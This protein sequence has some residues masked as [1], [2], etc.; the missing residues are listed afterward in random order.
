MILN[1]L[2]NEGQNIR[3]AYTR[4]LPSNPLKDYYFMLRNTGNTNAQIIE[5]GFLDSTKDDSL[6]LKNSWQK[7]AE[8]VV[9]A[10]AKY[11]NIPYEATNSN[12][13]IVRVGDTLW[14]IAKK[15]NIS[16]NELK[17]INN[18]TNNLLKI[19]M[20]LQIPNK[21]YSSIYVVK[22]GDTLY[23]IAKENSISVSDLKSLNNITSD[24]LKVGQEILVKDSDVQSYI[25]KTGDTLFNIAQR[26]G[27][28][29]NSIKTLNSLKN[30]ILTIGQVL[31]IK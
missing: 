19:G 10:I 6:Q 29:V 30:D 11:L 9:K 12:E 18:L 2:K 27:T 17:K 4:R 28:T 23:S 14:S 5:Y 25:V 15:Y 22:N 26:F 20:K 7:Y 13:Y 16:V 24:I 3:D 21:E 1:N 8:S 31:N